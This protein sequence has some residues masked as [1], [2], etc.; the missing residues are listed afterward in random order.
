MDQFNPMYFAIDNIKYIQD[1]SVRNK[2]ITK[3]VAFSLLFGVALSQL[4]PKSPYLLFYGS[5][6]KDNSLL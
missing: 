6:N 5:N 1:L 4:E 3:H 2:P